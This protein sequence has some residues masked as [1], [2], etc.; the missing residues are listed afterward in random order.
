MFGKQNVRKEY[1]VISKLL[2]KPGFLYDDNSNSV[3][4][5]HQ[6]FTVVFQPLHTNE[7]VLLLAASKQ[8]QPLDIEAIQEVVKSIP[9]IDAIR[10]EEYRMLIRFIK[11]SDANQF[12]ENAFY[13]L[14]LF[15][16]WMREHGY[17][18][19][20]ELSGIND[21]TNP[22][23]IKGTTM[24][25]NDSSYQIVQEE[26]ASLKDEKQ[27]H[28]QNYIAGI[29]GAI[30]GGILGSL[31]VIL[32]GQLGYFT[33]LAGI[34]LAILCIKGYQLLAGH[35]NLISVVL[36]TCLLILFAFIA[37]WL[38]WGVTVMKYFE[39]DYLTAVQSIPSL[40]VGEVIDAKPFIMEYVLLYVCVI[41]SAIILFILIIRKQKRKELIHK[42]GEVDHL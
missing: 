11:E 39:T 9:V 37:K 15:L 21:E 6:G 25:L 30:F 12:A 29:L 32:N 4:G 31:L 22:Y 38:D 23:Y 27:F 34:P 33:F 28:R 7:I 35:F 8:G 18:N 41:L 36:C 20:D 19:C 14:S 2:E 16:N 1:P 42:F 3:Y 17:E 24:L 13:G 10:I 40:L 26:Y 5:L